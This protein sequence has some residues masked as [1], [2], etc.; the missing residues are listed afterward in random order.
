VENNLLYKLIYSVIVAG[1]NA[2]FAYNVM[3]KLFPNGNI[4]NEIKSWVHDDIVGQ[5]VKEA[6]TGNYTKIEKAIRE[7]VE[8]DFNLET[9]TIE[10]L[11]SI[12]GIGPKTARFF[13]LWTR[14]DVRCA[15]LDVHIL[16]FLKEMGYDAPR[17]TP[18]AGKKYKELEDAFIK[19]ADR[20][21]LTPAQL[22][23][24]VWCK[25]AGKEFSLDDP[26]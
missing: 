7:I 18:P 23:S 15:A 20:V 21:G 2:D 19:E 25:G 9:C 13:M 26:V 16:R 5:K 11:E 3:A 14:P 24:Y 1:K 12:S 10:D 4:E 17:T 8:K 22:D 6:R